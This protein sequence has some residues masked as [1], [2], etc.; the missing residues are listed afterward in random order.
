MTAHLMLLT[1]ALLIAREFRALGVS[2]L[3]TAGLYISLS[4]FSQWFGDQISRVYRESLLTGLSFLI[5]ALSLTMFRLL[6]DFALQQARAK[7]DLAR[8]GLCSLSLG[9]IIS[10]YRI[11]KPGWYPFLIFIALTCCLAFFTWRR[12]TRIRKLCCAGVAVLIVLTS[13]QL[14]GVYVGRQNQKFYGIS[15]I[16]TFSEGAFPRALNRWASVKPKSSRMYVVIDARQREAVYKV[17]PTAAKLAP[18]LELS[19]GSGWRGQAC[20]HMG[21]CDES[22]AWFPWDLRDAVQAAGLGKS[23]A[24]FERSLDRIANDISIACATGRLKCGPH[25]L[26]PGVQPVDRIPKRELLDAISLAATTLFQP[27][28]VNTARG[29]FVELKKDSID[30]WQRTVKGLPSLSY[31]SPYRPGARYLV[32][33]VQL[34]DKIQKTLW[35]PLIIL[36]LLGLC[37]KTEESR[38]SKLQRRLGV[39]FLVSLVVYIGQLAVLEVSSGTFVAIGASLYLLPVYPLFISSIFLGLSRLEAGMKGRLSRPS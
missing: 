27:A 22:T 13:S 8:I 31:Q 28:D 35:A 2:R 36:G 7:V 9:L 3:V 25:G 17:S 19:V 6:R 1:G 21:I 30:L 26:G 23:A 12:G 24:Q 4:L 33:S 5:I 34:I 10:W 38:A 32:S 37:W 39:T 14:F 20:Q 16:D 18:F 11:T 15:G 29:P